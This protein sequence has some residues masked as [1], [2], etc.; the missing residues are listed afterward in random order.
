MIEGV[1]SIGGVIMTGKNRN[2]CRKFCLSATFFHDEYHIY[3]PVA[4][5]G[6]SR[7]DAAANSLSYVRQLSRYFFTSLNR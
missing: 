7:L 5:R 2:S 1:W 4:D 6:S 3:W